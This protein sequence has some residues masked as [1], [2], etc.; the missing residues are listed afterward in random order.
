MILLI[1]AMSVALFSCGTTNK[2]GCPGQIT[3]QPIEQKGRI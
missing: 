1:A 2:M 3:Q